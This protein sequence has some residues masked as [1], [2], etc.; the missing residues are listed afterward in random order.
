MIIQSNT[1]KKITKQNMYGNYAYSI[2]EKVIGKWIDNKPIY[3][4]VIEIN[5]LADNGIVSQNHSITN[6]NHFTNV[7]GIAIRS[8]DNDTL[9]IP[10]TTSNSTNTGVITMY[11]NDTAI[12]INATSDRSSYKAYVILEYTKTTD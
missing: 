3:R 12:T 11:V 9:P 5:A 8:S 4:K 7:Y 10:Y 2:N 6:L 1:N